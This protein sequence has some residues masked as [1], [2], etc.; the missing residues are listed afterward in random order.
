M[1]RLTSSAIAYSDA[2]AD[3]L[4][5]AGGVY[6][7][8]LDV[9]GVRGGL[10]SGGAGPMNLSGRASLEAAQR[11]ATHYMLMS[12]GVARINSGNTV[13]VSRYGATTMPHTEQQVT[14]R[15]AL[16][17]VDREHWQDLPA[18]LRPNT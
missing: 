16:I 1:A 6:L 15:F 7:G 10:E 4:K 13:V 17:R 3:A 8:E 14:A 18:S 5:G 12:G 2:D 9:Y 11:G